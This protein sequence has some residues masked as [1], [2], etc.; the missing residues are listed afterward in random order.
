MFAKPLLCNWEVSGPI[1]V[2]LEPFDVKIDRYF[3]FTMLSGMLLV[4][5][6]LCHVATIKI[7]PRSTIMNIQKMVSN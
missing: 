3:S 2:P 7:P 4:E 1:S 5:L 6:S